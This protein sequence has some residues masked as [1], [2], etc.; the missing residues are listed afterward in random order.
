MSSAVTVPA[1]PESVADA[2][3]LDWHKKAGEKV[4]AGDNLV[5]L[6]TDKV[7]LE[8]PAP[9]SGTLTKIVAAGGSRVSAGDIIAYIEAGAVSEATA[10]ENPPATAPAPAAD[11]PTAVPQPSV[12]REAA[13]KLS[14]AARKIAAE[15]GISAEEI[16][17]SGKAGRIRKADVQRYAGGGR[18]RSEERIPMTRMR[19]RI[20]ERLLEA[21]HNAAMLTTF[22]EVNMAAVLQLRKQYQ[23][24]FVAK[25]G[26]KLGLMSFFV[27][28]CAKALKQYP[29]VNAAIDGEEIIYHNYCDIGIAV[30]APRGLVVPVLRHAE[31]ETFA[32][33]EQRISEFAGKAKDNSLRIEEMTGGTF[34]ITNG[35]T[36]GSMLSTPII[37]PP[38]SAILGMHNI[39]ERPIAQDGAV[40]IA[41]MMYLA[42]SYDHRLID[43]REAVG[44]LVA[45]KQCIEDPARL[46]FAL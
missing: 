17:G 26:I 45:V 6:E 39:I 3:L 38:Q 23:S 7:V 8:M 4:A 27:K 15:Q 12:A 37:N 21:Q 22:N 41:P 2:T 10:A 31:H 34:T 43:G 13:K 20:A 35:G 18:Q 9:V 24:D 46:L 5:D 33:I 1:L 40:V 36:F 25:H 14:P 16:P 19:K 11:N 42:L 30:S 44:F 32:G 28:A 29:A